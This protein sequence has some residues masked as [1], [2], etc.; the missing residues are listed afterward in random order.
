MHH[1]NQPHVATYSLHGSQYE[2]AF[3]LMV[4]N[5]N[6]YIHPKTK[7]QPHHHLLPATKKLDSLSQLHENPT[8]SAMAVEVVSPWLLALF[9][10]P[11]VDARNPGCGAPNF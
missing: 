4:I 9:V 7:K 3:F 8:A 2:H 10:P 5:L 11:H 1:K 6:L